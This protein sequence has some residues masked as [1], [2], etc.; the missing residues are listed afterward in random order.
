[1]FKH[2]LPIIKESDLIVINGKTRTGKTTLV[3]KLDNTYTISKTR[4]AIRGEKE[5]SICNDDRIGIRSDK[6]KTIIFDEAH[7]FD[8]SEKST[9]EL[10]SAL[11]LAVEHGKQVIFCTQRLDIFEKIDLLNFASKKKKDLVTITLDGWCVERKHQKGFKVAH[12]GIE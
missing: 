4:N 5:L 10:I 7:V 6:N 12:Q 8:N 3:S 2:I 9:S 1:M 11:E